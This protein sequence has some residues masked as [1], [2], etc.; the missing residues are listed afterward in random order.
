MYEY[1]KGEIAELSPARVVIE[2]AGV[3]YDI[4]ISLQTYSEIE[5][6]TEA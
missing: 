4:N 6:L 2:A 5:K 1:I 3:G